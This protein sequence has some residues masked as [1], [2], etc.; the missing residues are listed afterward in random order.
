MLNLNYNFD[1]NRKKGYIKTN[2]FHNVN[3]S[4]YFI[5]SQ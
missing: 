4:F 1:I 2:Y 5:I 3:D